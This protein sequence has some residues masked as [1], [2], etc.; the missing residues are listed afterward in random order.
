MLEKAVETSILFDYYGGLLTEKQRQIMELRFA[1][2]LSLAEIA[3]QLSISR[4][5]VHDAIQRTTQQLF[6]YEDK[7][8][9]LK[10]RHLRHNKL[11]ILESQLREQGCLSE[12]I[13]QLINELM[14]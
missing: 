11:Q 4:Q 14:D 1:E 9:L 12:G 8:G 6:D 3:E 10:I 7:L 5:A 13:G 2:D